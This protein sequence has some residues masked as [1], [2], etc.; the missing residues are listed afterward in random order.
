MSDKPNVMIVEDQAM[1]R[2]L[3]EMMVERSEKYALAVAI[4]NAAVADIYCLNKKIDL[5]LMDVVTKNGASGLAAAERIK[6]INPIIKIIIVTSMPEYS[7]I[8]RARKIGAEGFWYKDASEEPFMSVV[9]R[10]MDGETVYPDSPPEMELG[11]AKSAELTTRELEVLRE[12]T[13]GYTN[14]EIAERLFMSVN[15]VKKHIM[16]MIEKTGFRNRTE[17][18]VR[19]RESGIVILERAD[20]RI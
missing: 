11:L 19:A 14:E 9:D 1:S 2:Q 6:K 17:L 5:V 18:A 3:F 10:V 13:G 4:D 8:D 15:T 16:S 12:M 20:E 7:Y